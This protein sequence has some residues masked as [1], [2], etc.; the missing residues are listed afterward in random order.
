M[1]ALAYVETGP[2]C[3]SDLPILSRALSD[4]PQSLWAALELAM[5]DYGL[6]LDDLRQFE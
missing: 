1:A 6:P 4:A 5:D 3:W 2:P